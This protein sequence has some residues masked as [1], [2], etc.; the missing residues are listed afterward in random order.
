MKKYRVLLMFSFLSL[1][2]CNAIAE[3]T[4]ML[5]DENIKSQAAGSLGYS[6]SDVTVTSKRTD[7]TNTYV[8]ITTPD[9][10]EFSCII[11][12]G[13]LLTLGMTNPPACAPKGQSV[14]ATPLG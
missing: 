13:N 9:K 12:G 1:A 5:S 11:N 8:V 4:N 7:G 3:K 14:K 2:G 10:K 6:P